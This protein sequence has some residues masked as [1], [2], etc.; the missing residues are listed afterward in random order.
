MLNNDDDVCT[1]H[2][3]LSSVNRTVQRLTI[4]GYTKL[5]Q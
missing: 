2:Y 4:Q 5:H 1:Q 3:V